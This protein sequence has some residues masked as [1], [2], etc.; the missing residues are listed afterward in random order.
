MEDM[1]RSFFVHHPFGWQSDA[2][3]DIRGGGGPRAFTPKNRFGANVKRGF[4][5]A[6]SQADLAIQPLVGLGFRWRRMGSGRDG[7]AVMP[8]VPAI[9]VSAA[10]VQPFSPRF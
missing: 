3:L 1:R 4:Y 10:A 5:G 7:I 2:R 8:A 9:S 6:Q